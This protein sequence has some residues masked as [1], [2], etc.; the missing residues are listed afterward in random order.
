[1]SD[2]SVI[3]TTFQFNEFEYTFGLWKHNSWLQDVEYIQTINKKTDDVIEQYAL[4]VYNRESILDIPRD[5]LQFSI[6]DQLFLD[7]FLMEI[8]GKSISYRA[9][10]K[11]LN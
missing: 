3:A 5:E 7:T 6:S 10:K 11:K 2:H 1:M 4:P 8:R 9:Y